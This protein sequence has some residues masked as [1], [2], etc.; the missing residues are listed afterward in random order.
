MFGGRFEDSRYAVTILNIGAINDE[1]DHQAEGVDYALGPG[2]SRR[3]QSPVNPPRAAERLAR[4]CRVERPAE[5][6]PLT[7]RCRIRRKSM[8]R[9]LCW[10]GTALMACKPDA[11]T[12]L[13]T[14]PAG[15]PARMG[16]DVMPAF[17]MCLA[18]KALTRHADTIFVDRCHRDRP[19]K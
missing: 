15:L 16:R 7:H 18:R 5:G 13:P 3:H 14:L 6:L 9:G 8:K 1:T 17:L 4:A 2:S 12:L 11:A 19:E 10:T